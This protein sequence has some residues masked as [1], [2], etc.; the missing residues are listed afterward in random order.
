MKPLGGFLA[1]P[2]QVCASYRPLACPFRDFESRHIRSC[3]A[4][5]QVT[6]QQAGCDDASLLGVGGDIGGYILHWLL[7]DSNEPGG[8]SVQVLYQQND[9]DEK[10]YRRINRSASTALRGQL[11]SPHRHSRPW[12]HHRAR[13]ER[14][15]A[16]YLTK[17]SAAFPGCRSSRSVTG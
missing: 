4:A 17:L 1:V 14:C 12:R 9:G 6:A 13:S 16:L 7:A 2:V 11:H 8:W 10:Q 15:S 3:E 5:N